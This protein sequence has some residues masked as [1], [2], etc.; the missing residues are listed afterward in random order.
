MNLDEFT[1]DRKTKH[2]GFGFFV[3]AT[4]GRPSFEICNLDL[5]LF[6]LFRLSSLSRMTRDRARDYIVRLS[7][8][9]TA[10]PSLLAIS[11]GPTSFTLQVIPSVL[12]TL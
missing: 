8:T 6:R 12:C 4:G 2:V 11:R 1:V 3:G 5:K 9:R 7:T 10:L